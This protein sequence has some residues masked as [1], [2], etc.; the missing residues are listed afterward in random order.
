MA[1]WVWQQVLASLLVMLALGTLQAQAAT[2]SVAANATAIQA[3]I[4][5][6]TDN[7]GTVIEIAGGIV[8]TTG[9]AD[10]GLSFIKLNK[11]GVT[12]RGSTDP[13]NPTIFQT[14]I[15]TLSSGKIL[16]QVSCLSDGEGVALLQV[17]GQTNPPAPTLP[18]VIENIIFKSSWTG[19]SPSLPSGPYNGTN[20]GI[21]IT[22]SG[23]SAANPSIIRNCQFLNIWPAASGVGGIGIEFSTATKADKFWLIDSNIFDNTRQGVFL[24]ANS[25]IT[26]KQ[27]TL[28][29]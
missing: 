15:T 18:N 23:P 11:K 6:A 7:S 26:I 2:V 29:R 21:F 19:N 12:L 8:T 25:Y 1:G 13:N 24:N 28:T 5:A 20:K 17:C 22:A 14:N 16:N 10:M 9:Y 4:N 27:N 3:A